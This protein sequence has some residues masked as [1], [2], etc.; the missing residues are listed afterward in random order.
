MGG[1]IGGSQQATQTTTTQISPE[2]KELF[3]LALPSSKAFAGHTLERFPFQQTLDFNPNQV[4]GQNAALR[5]AFNQQADYDMARGAVGSMVG[6][7]ESD[8]STMSWDPTVNP[9]I[10]GAI[11]AAQRPLYD[12]LL[13]QVLPGI[14]DTAVTQG[15]GGSRQGVAEGLAAGRTQRAAG[16]VASKIVQDVYGANLNAAGQRY[17]QNINALMAAAGILPTLQTGAIQPGLTTSNVGDVQQAQL[18]SQL[19]EAAQ[20]FNWDVNKTG[21]LAQAQEIMNLISGFPGSSNITTANTPKGSPF[22]SA[23]GG[24]AAGATLGSMFPV[25]GTGLGA[26]GG[27]LAGLLFS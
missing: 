10:K 18:A 4:A 23:L 13:E 14:R 3:N 1:G 24:A 2:A 8:P 20:N 19:Q 16:D 21:S 25:V 7:L 22:S 11:T 9:N 27:G 12:Q 17:G 15:Y 26:I 5:G 6:G